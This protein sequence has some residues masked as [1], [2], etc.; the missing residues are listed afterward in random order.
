MAFAR[1]FGLI[2]FA[3]LVVLAPL[4]YG[5]VDRAWQ[6]ML[7]LIFAAGVA[8]APPAQPGGTRV[9]WLLAGLF[10]GLLVLKE[11]F[12]NVLAPL[13][14]RESLTQDYGLPMRA[15]GNPQP[16]VA[17]ELLVTMALAVLWFYWV[18][19]L[20]ADTMRPV[21]LSL[22]L[23]CSATLLSVVS[24][25]MMQ[26]DS[27][28]I[29]GVRLVRGWQQFGPFPNRNHTASVLAM[30]GVIGAGCMIHFIKSK[31]WSGLALCSI[32]TGI[33][34]TGLMMSRSRGALLAGA[35]GMVLL[36]ML[37]GLHARSRKGLGI[38]LGVA[39]LGVAAALF[40]RGESMVRLLRP[41]ATD[42]MSTVGRFEIWKDCLSMIRDAPWFGHGLGTFRAAFPFYKSMNLGNDR[43][44]H[45]ES[46]WML[47]A[48]E[49]GLV[50][51]GLGL[52]L[53]V[54]L[55]FAWLRLAREMGRGF[56]MRAAGLCGFLVLLT[57]SAYD[58]P[59][60]RWA[61]GAFGLAA[62]ATAWPVRKAVLMPA[63]RWAA[64]PVGGV[65]LLWMM[66]FLTGIP[67]WSSGAR[68]RLLARWTEPGAV[69]MR[70][71]ND[72]VRA[73]PADVELHQIA[74]LYKLRLRPVQAW[75]H[76]SVINRLIP[77]S[78]ILP[79]QQ[80][81]LAA[82]VDS[83]MAL[84]YW[85]L[86]IDRAGE[87]AGEVF[88]TARAQTASLPGADEFWRG[89]VSNRPEFILLGRGTEAEKAAAVRYW[90]AH[91]GSN[92]EL[93]P[94]ELEAFYESLV[95]ESLAEEFRGWRAEHPE[96]LGQHAGR[97]I[98]I[99]RQWGAQREAWELLLKVQPAP[100]YSN[101]DAKVDTEKLARQNRINPEDWV[102]AQMLVQALM[103]QG[104]VEEADKV[105]MNSAQMQGAPRW[106]RV[107][108][109][110]A[111][112]RSGR[113]AEAVELLQNELT[114]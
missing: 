59:A 62:L 103:A 60:G 22:I 72:A 48:V 100:E 3:L 65:A 50:P 113:Y 78:W 90:L 75:M 57:H 45:P 88:E 54:L 55:L 49:L 89:F 30:G 6:S 83:A 80:A 18:R 27:E 56:S 114:P 106:F 74:A 10:V 76:F 2:V 63:G 105:L 44:L 93:F 12:S 25:V 66:G 9:H 95:D 112:A 104:R 8:V 1:K 26:W 97:W 47:W 84:S 40:T 15:W 92:K 61:A 101:V 108:A 82:E 29:Y 102:N 107:R 4:L 79:Q 38:A 81:V 16:I 42:E 36:L 96:L 110:H 52:V 5:A 85:E 77:D 70:G 43:V 53:L 67:T 41:D 21:Q 99:L 34:L 58:V 7:L 14:W 98:E 73:F 23:L 91:R 68:E 11:M 39:A 20:I 28:L 37:H 35:V 33:C 71:I 32:G 64:V 13:A 69:T 31:A 111:A 109:A 87:R 86:A 46:G 51:L 94:F 19:G 17:A 24:L